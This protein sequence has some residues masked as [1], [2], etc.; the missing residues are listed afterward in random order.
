MLVDKQTSINY[1][2]YLVTFVVSLAIRPKKNG[3]YH[4]EITDGHYL[5][6]IPLLSLQT[7]SSFIL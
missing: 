1:T 3:S 7:L 5:Q 2:G 6:V 4:C